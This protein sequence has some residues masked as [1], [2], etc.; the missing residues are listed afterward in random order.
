MNVDEVFDAA[1]EQA[2]GLKALSQDSQ[3][4]LY[5]LY[6][7]AM[8]GDCSEPKPGFFDFRGKAKWA[9]WDERRGLCQEEAKNKYIKFVYSK[10]P[11]EGDEDESENENEGDDAT[12]N[13]IGGR[14]QSLPIREDEP[15]SFGERTVFDLIRD[16]KST[17]EDIV[18][19]EENIDRL[20]DPRPSDGCTL[21]HIACDLGRV[22]I[23][24]AMIEAGVNINAVDSDHATGL[25]YACTCGHRDIVRLLLDSNCDRAIRDDD[26]N[27]AEECADGMDILALFTTTT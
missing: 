1:C 3:L 19:F 9:A 23:V 27:T 26:G 7:Q 21:F 15:V 24:K 14:V 10:L 2:K 12:S 6:K 8:F 17:W 11:K 13:A 18:A 25:H 4:H 22:S 16:D 20:M 5:G